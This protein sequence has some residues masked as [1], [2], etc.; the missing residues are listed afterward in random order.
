[1]T[2]LT[3][4]RAPTN[5]NTS[6]TTHLTSVHKGSSYSLFH[7]QLLIFPA[8]IHS[9]SKSWQLQ[10]R[11]IVVGLVQAAKSYDRQKIENK[12]ENV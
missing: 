9:E 4:L 11:P 5:L 12:R 10:F 1:M 6:T 7:P 2:R 8:L 3:N